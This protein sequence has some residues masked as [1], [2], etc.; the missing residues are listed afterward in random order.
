[1]KNKIE[2][3][4]YKDKYLIYNRK[5]TDDA[6]NQ[7]NSLIYQENA[8]LSFSKR[9]N[10]SIAEEF[11]LTNLCKSG[12]INESHSGYKEDDNFDIN[13]D[14]SVQY[15]IERPK[16]LR[17]IRL[18]KN[19][20]FKGAIF[21]C[22][23][24]ASR[25]KQD[26]VILKKL[27]KLGC[28]IRFS[29]TQY[30]KT[31]SGD[32]H[33][34]IDGMFASHYSNVISEKVRLANDKLRAE[35]RC[36][37]TSPIGYLDNGS[38]D[39]PIDIERAS[40]VKR[41][42]EL[43]ATG[44]WSFRQL[45]KWANEKGLTTKPTRK[46]RTKD[47][48]LSNTPIEN[49]GKIARPISHK[50]I[51]N[52]LKNPFY[53]GKLKSKEQITDGKYHQPLIDVA[54]FNKVQEVLKSRCI[55]VHYI[56]KHFSTYRALARCTC[57]RAYSAYEQKGIIYY[58]TR[59]ASNCGNPIKNLKEKDI[60]I[61]VQRVLNG[62]YFSNDE[63]LEIELKAHIGLDNI[64]VKRNKELDDLYA[65]QKR[66]FA[67]MDYLTKNRITLLRTN[68][69]SID[70]LKLDED[71]L[72]AETDGINQKIAI[73]GETAQEMLR[74]V[75][76]FS[77]LV[78]NASLY[79]KF[80]LDSEKREIASLVFTELIFKDGKL[81]KYT[82]KDGYD[83]LLKRNV[84]SGSPDYIFTELYNI[85]SSVIISMKIMKKYNFPPP[86]QLSNRAV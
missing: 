13:A 75:L 11:T 80:A 50:S 10:L 39:K 16:F 38:A 27:M 31:S 21:L 45:G 55:S 5:S 30:D 44:E 29:Q 77:E 69:M 19:K 74:Y 15:R 35:G 23:D 62:I 14:G 58:R 52:M 26:D 79:Y 25:N 72:T 70:R 51:E 8:N 46:H 73:Y 49:T 54:L 86:V 41:I 48:I 81:E 17:L 66:V 76:T 3:Q 24:R 78:K 34:D 28:D 83:A 9:E 2:N 82:A 59:C 63:L 84:L 47:E 20:E 60:H 68:S 37:Y 43:Y 7:K 33:M 22:W 6:E 53:I 42:F 1:M 32:L 4:P 61:E 71:R 67:D 36:L 85:Y 56:D 18:L 65:Q 64:A 12:I 40:I 57:G